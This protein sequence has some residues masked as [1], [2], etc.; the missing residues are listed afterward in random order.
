MSNHE[1]RKK[2]KKE[3]KGKREKERSPKE[4]LKKK[5]VFVNSVTLFTNPRQIYFLF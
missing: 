1:K 5:Y 4:I 2:K 3:K